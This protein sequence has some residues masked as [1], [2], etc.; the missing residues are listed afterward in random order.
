MFKEKE[1]MSHSHMLPKA[2]PRNKVHS[3]AGWEEE[4]GLDA[5]EDRVGRK[6][7]NAVPPSFY[8]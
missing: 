4:R 8:L 2:T 5:W 6:T 1:F 3:K 7:V